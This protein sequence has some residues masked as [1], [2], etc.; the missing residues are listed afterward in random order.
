MSAR[1]LLRFD[2][3]CPGMNWPLWDRLEPD[4]MRAGV[5]P[6]MAVVPSNQD[7]HLNVCAPAQ[8]FWDRVRRWQA[9]GW[10]IGLH[11]F[12]H[13]YVTNAAGIIG[14]NRYS[15][16]AGLPP[17]LQR[18]KLER[19]V[20]IFQ[21]QGV[22]VDA[23]VA[24][25]H[26]FDETTLDE[27]CR[28]GIKC[29]SD[30]YAL[31]PYVCPRGMLWIPQQLGRFRSMPFGIWTV[32]LHINGW[33]TADVNQFRAGLDSYRPAITSL[34]RVRRRYQARSQGWPDQVFETSFRVL[35]L[36]RG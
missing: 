25:A 14:R 4:L 24:P 30:G 36:L 35:R 21:S 6:L 9:A 13:R 27:L 15:E 31:Y 28:L 29:V 16:F 2:D 10:A 1:Y 32:C 26:S 12:E 34:R 5:K 7:P 18:A 11:G 8:G 19:A 33:K 22:Q 20:E 17:E 3:I 23:W